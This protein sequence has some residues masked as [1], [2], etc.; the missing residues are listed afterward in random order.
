[1]LDRWRERIDPQ[2]ADLVLAAALVALAE[3]SIAAGYTRE[4][5]RGVAMP[6][7]LIT[8]G[9][10]A[11]RRRWPLAMAVVFTV[12][13]VAQAV[14]GRSFTAL[15]ALVV[16]IA[17]VYSIGAHASRRS[18]LIGG[19]LVLAGTWVS[20][21]LDPGASASDR[22]FT[23]PV[24]VGASWLAGWLVRRHRTQAARLD[25]LNTELERRR[26][27]DL[28]HAVEQERIHIA[29]ELHDVIAH[30]ISVMVVQAGAAEQLSQAGTPALDALRS[31]RQT[32]KGA[33]AEMRRL[34]GVL[35]PDT[36]EPSLGPQP[37]LGDLPELVDRMRAAGMR[38]ELS[39]SGE[40]PR[41]QP[42]P[43]LAAY[44]VVQEALTN[45]LKHAAGAAV[46]VRVGRD[47][48]A[49]CLDVVDDGPA[50]AASVNGSG[51]GLIGMRER[52]LLY[53]GT[54]EAGPKAA[55]GW[56]VRVRMPADEEG[57]E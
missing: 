31:I 25:R 56:R 28:R 41:L 36:A 6:L 22:A 11:V 40:L 21:L 42:G 51:H 54:L 9:S 18:A 43:D 13:M 8:V 12:G 49:L 50:A 4:G 20:T 38:V 35:R 23:A 57:P 32:G 46:E 15:W 34:L 3:I 45:A 44:R 55:G 16:L 52:L 10:L 26:A 30:S 17:V 24:L 29:R 48:G 7:A 19:A 53:G 39:V 27:E 2:V 5:P 47:A 1:M 37:G 14:A 33:L